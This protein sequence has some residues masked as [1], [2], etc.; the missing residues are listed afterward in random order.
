MNSQYGRRG[1]GYSGPSRGGGR[2]GGRGRRPA[3]LSG[4]EIGMYYKQLSQK[5]K[6]EREKNEVRP[7]ELLTGLSRHIF[8]NGHP[9]IAETLN[10]VAHLITC[11]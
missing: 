7:Y 8:R 6:A 2:G 10:F 1:R 9:K 3:G 4:K 5:K 11:T